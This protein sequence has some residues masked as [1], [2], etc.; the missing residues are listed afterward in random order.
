MVLRIFEKWF[1]LQPWEDAEYVLDNRNN[2]FWIYWP[3][4]E[5]DVAKIRLFYRG[6]R[7][8]YVNVITENKPRLTLADIYLP[9]KHR[10]RGLG[11]KMMEELIGW[12]KENDFKLITGAVVPRDDITLEYLLKWYE[13]QGFT[14]YKTK[15]GHYQI[16]MQL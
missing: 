6:F 4:E 1:N 13:L 3:D 8:G 5:V 16:R 12:A 9:Q 10:K 15:T 14:L 7:S 11:K 2:K